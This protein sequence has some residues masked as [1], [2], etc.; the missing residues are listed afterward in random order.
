VPYSERWGRFRPHPTQT[1][2]TIQKKYLLPH[3]AVKNEAVLNDKP[4]IYVD[5]IAYF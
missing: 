3:Y 1:T 5:S 2:T 4:E